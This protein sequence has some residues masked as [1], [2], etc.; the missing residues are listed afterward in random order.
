MKLSIFSLRKTLYDGEAK[1]INCQTAD[2]E[3]TILDGHRPL[4]SILKEGVVKI[5]DNRGDAHYVNAKSGF[6]EVMPTN[7]AR[8]IVEE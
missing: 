2:G 7:E 1:S 4:A 8:F 5:L 3:V 6:L